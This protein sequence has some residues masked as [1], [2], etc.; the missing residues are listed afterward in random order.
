ME[1]FTSKI[2]CATQNFGLPSYDAAILTRISRFLDLAVIEKNSSWV[3]I[4]F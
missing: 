4:C 2:V 1:I 3:S